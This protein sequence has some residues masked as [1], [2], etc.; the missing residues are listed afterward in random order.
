MYVSLAR[1]RLWPLDDGLAPNNR[2]H[3]RRQEIEAT[4][5]GEDQAR[6]TPRSGAARWTWSL[7]LNHL[8]ACAISWPAAAGV[9]SSEV[10]FVPL[11]SS[12]LKLNRTQY[13]IRELL[14]GRLECNKL[15]VDYVLKR[16]ERLLVVHTSQET[17]TVISYY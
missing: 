3:H 14:L 1:D 9:I 4:P 15:V 13:A 6:Q 10:L 2:R 16:I 5:I 7:I 17:T 8:E 11:C 12:V